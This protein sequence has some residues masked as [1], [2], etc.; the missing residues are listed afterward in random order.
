MGWFVNRLRVRATLLVFAVAVL[1][2][3]TVTGTY[4]AAGA[5]YPEA[6]T[7]AARVSSFDELSER[8]VALAQKK[9]G[10]YAYEVLGR[11]PLPQG[12]DLHLLGH[13]VGEEL[14]E[15]EGIEGIALCTQDFRNACSHTIVIG[16]LGEYGESALPLIRESCKKAPGGAGAYT[17]CYH[18]LGHG[19]FAYYGYDLVQTAAFCKKTG[20]PEYHDQEYVECLGGAIMELMGGG[21]HDPALWQS[22]RERYLSEDPLSPCM[23]SE[24]PEALKSICLMYLTPRLFELAGADLANPDPALFPKAFSYCDALPALRGDLRN[25]CY[26]SFGKEFLPLAGGRDIR[27]VDQF[28][29]EVYKKV[30]GWCALAPAGDAAHACLKEALN[31]LFW[32]GENDPQASFRFCALAPGEVERAACYSA[33]GL[34]IRQYTSGA[35]RERLC[36]ALPQLAREACFSET[37]I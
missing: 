13:A 37:S 27:K 6:Q 34:N 36:G 5:L 8:F 17:M 20:T 29:D 16:A 14:Y 7:I 11:A 3:A 22:A 18:G 35:E 33:L 21:G 25:A 19:V 26:G 9:G 31:S 23:S 30:I 28:S 15:Q 4:S 12:T 2:V 1:C 32:G 24:V 10:A